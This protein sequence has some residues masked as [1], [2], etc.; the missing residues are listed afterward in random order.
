MADTKVP[1]LTGLTSL[2]ATDEIYI[3][4]KSDT[5]DGAD[6]TSKKFAVG[7]TGNL[8][9]TTSSQ[10]L[11][12]KTLTAPVI[13]TI[14]NT[15]TVTLPTDTDTLV[16]R[17]TTDTLTNKTL[18]SAVLNTGVSGTAIKDE[19]NMASDSATHLATQQSIKKYVDDSVDAI[20][21]SAKAR[22]F[23]S[24]TQSNIADASAT[25]VLLDGETYDVGG[26]FANN[27]F[28]APTTG[29]Y[30][31]NA[32]IFWQNPI[33]DKIYAAY[34]YKNGARI[35]LSQS[36]S[37][38][39]SSLSTDINDVIKLTATDYVELYAYH[40]SGAAT[41]DIYGD[42]AYTYMSIHLLST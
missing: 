34:L 3:I 13:S 37:S 30:Q 8:V 11:T 4:D 26:N 36:H 20:T 21:T 39:T 10:T 31:V 22:V 16:G 1:D 23:L 33:A 35:A 9:G 24:S 27:K 2:A 25:K 42:T 18:T 17:D 40:N 5:T 29:Y 14:S 32:T 15:G 41:P 6:G 28:T 7:I 19:D 38:S 12:N